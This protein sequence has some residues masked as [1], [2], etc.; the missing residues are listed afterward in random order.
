MDKWTF[1]GVTKVLFG[2]SL[3]ALKHIIKQLKANLGVWP[4]KK[5]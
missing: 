5:N 1:E 3:G 2:I 4:I